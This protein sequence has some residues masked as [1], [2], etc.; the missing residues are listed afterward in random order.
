M[1]L[2]NKSFLLTVY[3]QLNSDSRTWET[4]WW[5]LKY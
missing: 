3:Q 4:N 1:A 2:G 5:A